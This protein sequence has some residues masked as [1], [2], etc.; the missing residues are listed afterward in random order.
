MMSL[1]SSLYQPP[2]G[3]KGRASPSRHHSLFAPLNTN[4]PVRRCLRLPA[5]PPRSHCHTGLPNRCLTLQNA[6]WA[7][8]HNH[9]SAHSIRPPRFRSI[10]ETHPSCNIALPLQ[11]HHGTTAH[12]HPRIL[13]ALRRRRVLHIAHHHWLA[14]FAHHWLKISIFSPT[15]SVWST[16]LKIQ[17]PPCVRTGP[18]D[19]RIGGTMFSRAG[20]SGS[21]IIGN[22]T[23]LP[24]FSPIL[25]HI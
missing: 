1:S 4:L 22:V 2:H 10:T 25:T 9:D 16:L 17:F 23:H 18:P 7:P 6:R 20:R 15:S 8:H 11:H 19:L 5:C 14:K 24:S 3:I 13:R 21:S 12:R